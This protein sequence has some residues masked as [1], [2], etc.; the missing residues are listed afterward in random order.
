MARINSYITDS[1]ISKQDK[2]LGTDSSGSTRNYSFDNMV[3]FIARNIT[4]SNQLYFKGV[5]TA[6]ELS[7]GDFIVEGGG[8]DIA[9][10]SVTEIVISKKNEYNN[11]VENISSDMFA[12]GN[13][14]T[15]TEISNQNVFAEFTISSFTDYSNDEFS[16][17]QVTN[18][19][20]NGNFRAGTFY[21]FTSRA[22]VTG[23]KK[24]THN[25]SSP[26]TTWTIN[27]NLEK[28]PSV[29]VVDS[30]D[31]VIICEVEYTTD[32]QVV[33]TFDAST[34]GKAYIN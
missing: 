20:G 33:L 3:D 18:N 10:T 24:Y 30:A 34:S 6:D 27:H 28:K 12:V 29:T 32:N 26:S 17:L 8:D 23:D 11:T 25:Q 16:T 14:I 19:S 31:N 22:A 9:L 21:A 2:V 4:V 1:D 15:V 7:E 13:K 5:A